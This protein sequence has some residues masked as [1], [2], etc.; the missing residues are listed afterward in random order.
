MKRSCIKSLKLAKSSE[1]NQESLENGMKADSSELSGP[2]EEC[3]S[4][5]SQVSIPLPTLKK[6]KKRKTQ[7]LSYIQESPL[8]SKEM[9]SKD[10][11][12]T[13][14]N[15]YLS[16]IPD[17]KLTT[18]QTSALALTLKDPDCYK[19]WDASKKEIYQQLSWLQ[20]T[21]LPDLGSNSSNGY[22]MNTEQKSWFSILKIQPQN[23]NLEKTLWQSSKFTVVDGMEGGDTKLK[24]KTKAMK[25]RLKPSKE[26]KIMLNKWAGCARFLYNKTI[27]LLTNKK[28]KNLRG[29]YFLRDRLCT[30]MNGSTG[31]ENSFYYNKPWLKNC[32]KSIRQG[33]ICDAK[34]NLQA[35]F[36][37][38]KNQNI[39]KFKSPF[40][41][42]K[43][44]QLRG[45][46]FGL[47]KNNVSKKGDK[48]FI[49]PT[50]LKEMKYYST[51]QLHKI[52]Q[53][54]EEDII[55]TSKSKK[56]DKVV[57]TKPGMDCKIQKSAYGE[58]FLIVPYVCVPKK[59]QNKCENPVAIDPGVRKFLTTY[60]PNSRESFMLGNRWA[61]NVTQ[62]CLKLDKL[63][64]MH[65]KEKNV[66]QREKLKA[67]IK[68]KRKRIS[69]LKKELQDQCANFISKRY[70]TIMMPKLEAG[71]LCIKANRKLSS[72]TVRSFL[73]AGHCQFFDKLKDKCWQN[74]SK[75]LHVREEYTSQTCPCCGSLKKCN[76][77]YK[78]GNC[79]FKHDRDIV[80]AFNIF[81]KAVRDTKPKLKK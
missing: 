11:K 23:L 63:C 79:G 1:L 53:T 29:K 52:I 3:D 18:Y 67:S 19:F 12:T 40:R 27:G 16:N 34:S 6:S 44:E 64:S 13:L 26:Q 41:S 49:F 62:E 70:D 75:F 61:T 33:A 47:E 31:K 15:V 66:N 4:L 43:N 78:C 59:E 28:N 14:E 9:T 81:L 56:K 32:P 68:R 77:V 60:A 57:C 39:N 21:D 42:K 5:I 36:T 72:K 80:G 22:V 10:K 25:L 69:N 76:E 50:F 24:K 20:G 17:P 45:W 65:A 8:Q 71:K 37:N 55:K 38:L 35:C 2:Q 46:S 73:N 54:Q 51:K 30:I 74:G 48:L 7:V 58:Y